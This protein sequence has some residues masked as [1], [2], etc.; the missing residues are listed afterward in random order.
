MGGEEFKWRTIR[1]RASKDFILVHTVQLKPMIKAYFSG[2]MV[3]SGTSDVAV[4]EK[5]RLKKYDTNYSKRKKGEEGGT[6]QQTYQFT[7]R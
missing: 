7:Q 2:K 4:T 3:S 1:Y 6:E 5:T